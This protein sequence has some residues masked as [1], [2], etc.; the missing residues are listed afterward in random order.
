MTDTNSVV[1]VGR[2][3]R[4]IGDRDFGY[5]PTGTA[6]LAFSIA[7][8]KSKKQ[9]DQWVD[10][11]SYFDCVIFGKWAENLKQKLYKGCKV[12]VAGSLKQ[13]RWEKDGQKYSRVSVLADGVQLMAVPQ[14]NGGN[15]QNAPENGQNGNY[16]NGGN[17]NGY[18]QNEFPEDIPFN[19]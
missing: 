13:D 19:N 6:K 14:N 10:E 8:N 4:D 15:Y 12:L 1:L 16:Q 18:M 11:A 5:L 2:L 17:Y 9:G 7:V 3:V